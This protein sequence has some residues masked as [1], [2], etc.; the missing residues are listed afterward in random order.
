MPEKREIPLR[1]KEKENGK[2]EFSLLWKTNRFSPFS[3]KKTAFP[4]G[5]RCGKE[6]RK[7]EKQALFQKRLLTSRSFGER[8]GFSKRFP[9]RF[10]PLFPRG[11][12]RPSAE[13]PLCGKARSSFPQFPQALLLLLLF[14][15]I[16]RLSS[17]ASRKA[18]ARERDRKALRHFSK[19]WRVR[20][21]KSLGQRAERT[22]YF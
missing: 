21:I 7:E 11:I 12:N 20:K 3:T 17:S 2:T 15:C 16:Y 6:G 4:Q 8:R 22:P 9:Q 13:D 14:Y 18:S 5:K 1:R 10:P 19:D